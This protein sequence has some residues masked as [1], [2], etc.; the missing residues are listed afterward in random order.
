MFGDIP[1]THFCEHA[2][3]QKMLGTFDFS[4]TILRV[5]V[6]GKERNDLS[7]NY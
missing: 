1:E 5:E 2:E 3:Y 7:T 4:L 6:L